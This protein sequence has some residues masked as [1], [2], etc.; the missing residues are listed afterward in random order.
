MRR[1]PRYYGRCT[2]RVTG[3]RRCGSVWRHAM[4]SL[5][6]QQN[7]S[8]LRRSKRGWGSTIFMPR[9]TTDMAD[10][11]H[12]VSLF[13]KHQSTSLPEPQSEALGGAAVAA[14]ADAL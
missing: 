9:R 14:L 10:S 8:S 3:N 12:L 13:L 6:Y 2:D 4:G 7:P 1:W 11:S 5:S